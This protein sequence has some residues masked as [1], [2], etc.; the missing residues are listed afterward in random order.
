M[1][2]DLNSLYHHQAEPSDFE[3]LEIPFTEEEINE[4]VKHLPSDKSPRPD[5]FNNEFIKNCWD[6]IGDDVRKL[7]HDFY[8]G[9]VNLESINTHSKNLSSS[10]CK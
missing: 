10:Y 5:G 3:Q 7:I 8:D 6:I 1:H 9:D 4:V 2:F